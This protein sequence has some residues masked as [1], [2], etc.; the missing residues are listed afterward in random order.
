MDVDL[1]QLELRHDDLRIRSADRRRRLISSV[2]EVGQQVPVVV[3]HERERLVLIDGYLRVEALRSLQRDTVIAT[4]WPVSEAEALVHHR[5]LATAEHTAIEDAWL[6]ARLRAHG[7]SLDDLAA[8]LCRSKSWVSRRLAL[9]E[10]LAATAQASVRTG[11]VP[12][13][14]AMKYLVPLARA[15]RRHC[16]QLISN[17]GATRV[18]ERDIGTLYRAWRRSDS[19]GRQRIVAEPLLCLRALRAAADPVDESDEAAALHKDLTTLAAIA[20]RARRRVRHGGEVTA[21][22]TKAWCAASDAVAALGA[23]FEELHVGSDDTSKHS[24]PP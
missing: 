6:L 23:A 13:H 22:H 18:S 3:I 1:H 7:L 15:N 16:E 4:A 20:W 24:H 5:H 21:D 2:A 19:A 14:A 9:L 11:I 12:A 8:R 17:L 10:E